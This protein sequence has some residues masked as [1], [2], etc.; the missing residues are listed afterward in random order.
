MKIKISGILL[1][2]LLIPAC[3]LAWQGKV[4][5]IKDG[6][7][8]VVLRDK[9]E[10]D[11]RLYGID[12]PE[13]GQ[14]YGSRAKRFVAHMAGKER[15]EVDVRD[16]DRY[17]RKVALVYVEGD[18]KSLNEELVRAGYAWVYKRYCKIQDCD[19]WRKL[20]RQAR[21]ANKGL[22]SD[23]DPVPPWD[24]R[25][26]VGKDSKQDKNCSDFD[27][28]AEAQSFYEKHQPGDP[29]R[30]DGDGDGVACEGLP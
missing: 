30:L 16:T 2:L 8:I 12:T 29:H 28:Q 14:P 4:V 17:G 9:N 5:H 24:W 7:T 20:E 10:V 15:V 22:W 27:T 23:P 19:H 1:L 21:E 3:A 26:G 18:G 13:K 25:H 6:D 11:I